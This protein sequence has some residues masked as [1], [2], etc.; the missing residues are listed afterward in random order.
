MDVPAPNVEGFQRETSSL[1]KMTGGPISDPT[2]GW[3]KTARQAK[4]KASFWAWAA[5][6]KFLG[7][8]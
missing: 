8:G 1:W 6:N 4:I 5:E 2:I 3:Q 7:F